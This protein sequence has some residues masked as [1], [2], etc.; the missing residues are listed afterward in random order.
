M[1]FIVNQVIQMLIFF[2]MQNIFMKLKFKIK[3]L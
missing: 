3:R 1:E 2:E